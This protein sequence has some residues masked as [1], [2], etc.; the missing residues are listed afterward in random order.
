MGGKRRGRWRRSKRRRG[1]GRRR[2]RRRKRKRKKK[3]RR[4]KRR[5]R[6]RKRRERRRRGRRR[7]LSLPQPD[8]H[9]G[10]SIDPQLTSCSVLISSGPK[11]AFSS[12]THPTYARLVTWV[13]D[14]V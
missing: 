12:A 1:R 4:R 7:L 13:Q 2:K 11:A 8:W 5:K 14:I 10:T 3:R 6:R 9:R